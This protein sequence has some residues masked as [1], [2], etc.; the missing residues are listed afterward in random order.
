MDWR[1]K[2]S[3]TYNFLFDSP[4]PGTSIKW[5][6]SRNSVSTPLVRFLSHQMT[7]QTMTRQTIQDLV[8]PGGRP[9]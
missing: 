8:D 2:E 7:H 4:V 5:T 9:D 1:E 3:A 6:G